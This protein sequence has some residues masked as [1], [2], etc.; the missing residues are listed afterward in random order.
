MISI[1]IPTFNEEG[2][3]PATLKSIGNN[4][5]V[6]VVDAGSS[7]KT[8]EI[9]ARSGARV[10]QSEKRQRAAQMNRGAGEARGEILLFLHADTWLPPDA[11]QNIEHACGDP[12]IVGGGFRRRF[13]SHSAFLRLTCALA[14]WRC[15]AFGWFLGDQA[16][17]VKRSA[18]EV[19]GGFRDMPQFEDVDL[20]RRLKN[21]GR[22][23]FIKSKVQSS[24]RRFH[25]G[26]VRR[27]LMDFLLTSGYLVG[28]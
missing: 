24:A 13:R 26:P 4:L 25:K 8:C 27:T 19:I 11:F 12:K 7:D 5:D 6:I 15:R 14:D 16:I 18:F 1:I 9:A 22:L 10:I 3:L 23:V 21:R 17:F 28:K 2:E 20:C